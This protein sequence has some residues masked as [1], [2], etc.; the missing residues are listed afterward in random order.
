MSTHRQSTLTGKFLVS[1]EDFA[2]G[3]GVAM[4]R[5]MGSF[6]SISIISF[7]FPVLEIPVKFHESHEVL[8]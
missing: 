4:Q 6:D 7:S 5:L 2:F 8:R 1:I 3:G